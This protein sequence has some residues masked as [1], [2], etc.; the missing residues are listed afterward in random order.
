MWVIHKSSR[1][2]SENSPF[3]SQSDYSH[4]SVWTR[5]DLF[6]NCSSPYQ[7]READFIDEENLPFIRLGWILDHLLS[8]WGRH[9]KSEGQHFQT[10]WLR[11]S[12]ICHHDRHLT[13]KQVRCG[14]EKAISRQAN[15]KCPSWSIGSTMGREQLSIWLRNVVNSSK[16]CFQLTKTSDVSWNLLWLPTSHRSEVSQEW[17][18]TKLYLPVSCFSEANSFLIRGVCFV[19]N[20][21]CIYRCSCFCTERMS[22]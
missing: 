6:H 5:I 16:V 14:S 18:N 19:S 12:I 4:K 8:C 10:C 21:V 15:I 13:D 3:K 2:A 11:R 1:W 20:K 7:W 17:W 22:Q 9:K